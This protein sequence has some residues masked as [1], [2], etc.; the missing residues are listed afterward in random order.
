MLFD[1]FKKTKKLLH[2]VRIKTGVGLVKIALTFL[3]EIF[4]FSGQCQGLFKIFGI[5]LLKTDGD[6]EFPV[7]LA[8]VENVLQ[9]L[10][11]DLLACIHAWIIVQPGPE[12]KPART[13]PHGR[14]P[15]N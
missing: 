1:Q 7:R 4:V 11:L 3:E 14:K 10:F 2:I 5:M 6:L 8:R 9:F 13:R 12:V 15:V